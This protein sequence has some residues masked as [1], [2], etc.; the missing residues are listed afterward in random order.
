[1]GMVYE[2][3]NSLAGAREKVDP[4]VLVGLVRCSYVSKY[5]PC[6]AWNT[7]YS[8]LETTV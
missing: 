3:G 7:S 6:C 4:A 1:M 5:Y 2:K 8:C